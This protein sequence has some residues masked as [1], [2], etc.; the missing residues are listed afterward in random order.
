M[1][2]SFLTGLQTSPFPVLKEPNFSFFTYLA[3]Y[4]FNNWMNTLTVISLS[5]QPKLHGVTQMPLIPAEKLLL[6]CLK[7]LLKIV[8]FYYVYVNKKQTRQN[9]T[10]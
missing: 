1:K 2:V 3:F 5:F 6:K 9:A 8:I 4:L 7:L 10:W